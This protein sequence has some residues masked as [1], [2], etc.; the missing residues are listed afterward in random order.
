[1]RQKHESRKGASF[2]QDIVINGRIIQIPK[3]YQRVDSMPEDPAN[4]VSYMASTENAMCLLIVYSVDFS[5]SLPH[6]ASE[7]IS[8]VRHYLSENQGIIEAETDANHAYSIVKTIKEPSGVQYT[9]TYQRFLSDMI[10]Q[11]QGF[12]EENGITGIR[13]NVVFEMCRRENLVGSEDNPLDGWMSDPFDPSIT[14]G[15]LMNLSERDQFDPMFPDS[16]LSMCRG[17]VSTLTEVE[18]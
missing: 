6:D 10:I 7:L 2:S 16:P 4:S 18:V 14:R 17:V 12:F 8:G 9:L 3:Y 5:G 13:D 1:M 15:A 11:I